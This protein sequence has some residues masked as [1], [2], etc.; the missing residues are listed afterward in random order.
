MA[1]SVKFI[2]QALGESEVRNMATDATLRELLD[3][4]GGG[5]ASGRGNTSSLYSLKGTFTSLKQKAAS[6]ERGIKTASRPFS[7]FISLLAKNETSMSAFGTHLNESVIKKLPWVGGLLGS[8][9]DVVISG[10]GILESYERES[11]KLVPAGATFTQSIF[12]MM[13]VA[14]SARLDL[15][16]LQN[17][18]SQNIEELNALGPTTNMGIKKFAQFAD[19][20]NRPVEGV[21]SSLLN[22]GYNIEEV[23]DAAI[24]FL[25]LTQRGAHRTVVVNE[26]TQNDFL[27]YTRTLDAFQ[28]ITGK[29]LQAKNSGAQKIL[30]NAIVML[31]MN[32]LNPTQSAKVA[33]AANMSTL[34]FEEGVAEAFNASLFGMT[35]LSEAG[36]AYQKMN[37]QLR[38]IL[39][40][41][42]TKAKDDSVNI[43]QYKDI[44]FDLFAHM[45][46]GADDQLKMIESLIQTQSANP[47]IGAN[48]YAAISGLADTIVRL[49]DGEKLTAKDIKKRLTDAYKSQEETET[50]TEVIRSIEQ[51]VTEFKMGF[52][53][54]FMGEGGLIGFSRSIDATQIGTIFAKLGERF[55][56]F[57]EKAWDNLK[58]FWG[59]LNTPAGFAHVQEYIGSWAKYIA[60]K[61]L[62]YAQQATAS[63]IGWVIRKI[64]FGDKFLEF[65]RDLDDAMKRKFGFGLGPLYASDQEFKTDHAVA[66]FNRVAGSTK[67]PPTV[68]PQNVP[69]YKPPADINNSN[70]L[71]RSKV[72]N[73]SDA[74]AKELGLDKGGQYRYDTEMKQWRS[75]NNYLYGT[76]QPM[77]TDPF[78]QGM[79]AQHLIPDVNQDISSKL[80]KKWEGTSFA[81]GPGDQNVLTAVSGA[82]TFINRKHL[83]FY[84]S[85]LRWLNG[86]GFTI[87][88]LQ[89]Q[90]DHTG[91]KGGHNLKIE[92][93]KH[94]V[95]WF[96]Q[97]HPN[98]QKALLFVL[99][100]AGYL[101]ESEFSSKATNKPTLEKMLEY[102]VR[103]HISGFNTV[104]N[105]DTTRGF[106]GGTLQEFGR[107]VVDFGAKK[108]MVVSGDKAIMTKEQYDTIKDRARQ[109]PAEEMINTVNSTVQEMIRIKKNEIAIDRR[110]L[111]IA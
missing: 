37:P 41:L 28:K 27:V 76:N 46:A 54:G 69:G 80:T 106:S 70:I 91:F 47:L 110:M 59:Y 21:R 109:I 20:I 31:E 92:T 45:L 105:L 93:A 97:L 86:K 71:D 82:S 78:S 103:G 1:N 35:P 104:Q 4:I 30:R 12:E 9:S 55:V 100:N 111:S 10:V 18:V 26:T 60:S 38:T 62:I 75:Y 34:V 52:V 24:N 51:A 29:N 79:Y 56:E 8:V 13:Q 77:T 94:G 15:S 68:S 22:M 95:N 17:V 89:G 74:E 67:L 23:N 42:H 40:Q 65:W 85:I 16:Q 14:T 57:S 96:G 43:D 90:S 50:I 63:M 19:Y 64:P 73:L 48:E 3:A 2:H 53:K 66:D 58:E 6:L 107:Q 11:K 99:G 36:F 49:K 32:K 44:T 81:Q 7:G 33:L 61:A 98:D 84:S 88:S 72:L 83:D 39:E 101:D 5:G 25:F 108:R 87:K 102:L